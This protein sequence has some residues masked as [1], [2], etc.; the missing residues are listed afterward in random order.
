MRVTIRQRRV[1]AVEE[2]LRGSRLRGSEKT[3]DIVNEHE[4]SPAD[5][6]SARR[7]YRARGEPRKW[8]ARPI[9]DSGRTQSLTRHCSLLKTL[10]MR[11]IW[12]L[13]AVLAVLTPA[14]PAFAVVRSDSN[15]EKRLAKALRVPQV[16]AATSA[17]VAIDLRTGE[18][19]FA[20]NGT[21]ALAPASNEKLALTFAL[22]S[23][24]SPKTR[25]ET[26]VEAA[27]VQDGDT[28]HGNLVLVGGGDPTLSTRDLARLAR[29][30]RA[31]GIRHVTGGVVGDETLF[32]SKRTCPGWKHS[33]YIGESPPLSALVVDCARYRTYT[34]PRPAKAAALL[35]RDALRAAGGHR[36]VH[37]SAQRQLHRRGAAEAAFPDQRRPRQ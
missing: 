35:F 19:L 12:A 13:L 27:G 15:L 34:A 37:G 7:D 21:L 11:R 4:N 24:F 20:L 1:D 26:R 25:I 31:T 17:A 2:R 8:A 6:A 5:A 14:A 16:S 32:D 30:V 36:G 22:F 28:L 33:F 18:Q 3:V 10:A 9:F 23:S 29:R